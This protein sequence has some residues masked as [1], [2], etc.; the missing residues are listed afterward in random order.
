MKMPISENYL[1]FKT[2]AVSAEFFHLSSKLAR[3]E[4][5]TPC[6]NVAVRNSLR[7]AI[8]GS[9]TCSCFRLSP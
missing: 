3:F 8:L 2:N 6:M 1:I 7:G 4:M 5:L 9:V